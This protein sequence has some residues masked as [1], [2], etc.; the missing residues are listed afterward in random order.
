MDCIRD[1]LCC[2]CCGGALVQ[3]AYQEVRS[4]EKLYRAVNEGKLGEIRELYLREVIL[5]S[6]DF[7]TLQKCTGLREL[8]LKNIPFDGE[9]LKE[10]PAGVYKVVI[11]DNKKLKREIVNGWLSKRNTSLRILELQRTVFEQ[12]EVPAMKQAFIA[13]NGAEAGR[14]FEV[15]INK[16][17]E[18]D[19]IDEA[20]TSAGILA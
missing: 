13:A 5:C 12:D 14:Q 7:E 19:H 10:V 8:Y 17:C 16:Q 3:P 6:G 2:C 4:K 18:D 1:A 15:S 11:H 9:S 20:I